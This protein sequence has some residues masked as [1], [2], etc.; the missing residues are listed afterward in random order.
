[1]SNAHGDDDR[2]DENDVILGFCPLGKQK[3]APDAGRFNLHRE[4]NTAIAASGITPLTLVV[5]QVAATCICP[6]SR[7]VRTSVSGGSEILVPNY[8][9]VAQ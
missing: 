8:G 6:A 3:K 1:M 7:A 4:A 5:W 9:S 2:S